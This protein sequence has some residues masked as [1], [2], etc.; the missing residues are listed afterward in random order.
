MKFK[1]AGKLTVGVEFEFEADD[2]NAAEDR[3][4]EIDAG[5]FAGNDSIAGLVG[6]RDGGCVL[7]NVTFFTDNCYPEGDLTEV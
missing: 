2:L 5:A 6:L 1:F 7:P 4:M 3:I